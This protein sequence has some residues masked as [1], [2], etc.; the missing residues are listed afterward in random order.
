M[1]IAGSRLVNVA[2]ARRYHCITRCVR[3]AFV[4]GEAERDANRK[5]WIEQR[6]EDRFPARI[7]T[8]FAGSSF[9]G[10]GVDGV[11]A[12]PTSLTATAP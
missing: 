4:L 12:Y 9:G 8:R 3:R 10:M 11:Y 6:H 2:L 5:D 1:A 7:P